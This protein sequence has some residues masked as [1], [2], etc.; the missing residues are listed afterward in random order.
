[1]RTFGL[2]FGMCPQSKCVSTA[3]SRTDLLRRDA[4]R[5]PLTDFLGSTRHFEFVSGS[6]LDARAGYP[7]G[8]FVSLH[9]SVRDE[10]AFPCCF[11]PQ[12][13]SKFVQ[14]QFTT[15]I[16]NINFS[17]LDALS[18]KNFTIFIKEVSS[19]DAVF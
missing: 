6:P 14:S 3:N 15:Y 11:D 8:G 13:R 16:L 2:Q 17:N 5:V 12:R 7:Y 10:C 1:M 9:P 18:G 4:S 19:C